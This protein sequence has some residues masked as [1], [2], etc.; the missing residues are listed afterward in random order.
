[1]KKEYGVFIKDADEA[2]FSCGYFSCV[3]YSKA[4]LDTP[5]ALEI[6]ERDVEKLKEYSRRYNVAVR[7]FHIPFG[8][9]EYYRFEPASLDP[10][11]REETLALTKRLLELVIP[12]GIQYVVLHGSLRVLPEERQQKL[13]AF[14][15]YVQKLC[16]YCREYGISVAVETLKP[17]CIG[18]G[19]KEHLYI[20]EHANRENLG[21]CFDSNHL[22]EED[23]LDFL[24]GAGQYVITTHFSDYDGI[25]ER[26]WYPGRGINDW[27][28]IVQILAEKGYDSPYVSETSFKEAENPRCAESY[29]QLI[30]EWE[31][32]FS[33]N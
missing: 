20:K 24:R 28:Q 32:I 8:S 27:K 5:D 1:M 31:A 7:S 29:G 11:V 15:E 16:D 12:T 4:I 17:R 3:E 26:H 33:T 25:D 6:V 2:A 23:N 9:S 10:A 14:V 22:L 21:I 30:R 19:L 13:E 18:N